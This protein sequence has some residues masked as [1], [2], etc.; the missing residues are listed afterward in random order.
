MK[1]ELEAGSNEGLR[2]F[3]TAAVGIFAMDA[4]A[5]DGITSGNMESMGCNVNR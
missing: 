4:M 1:V 5:P 3:V 2:I